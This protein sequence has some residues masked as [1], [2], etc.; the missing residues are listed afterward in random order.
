[1]V[2]GLSQALRV[3]KSPVKVGISQLVEAKVHFKYILNTISKE[4][5]LYSIGE[6][7]LVNIVN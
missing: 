2:A 7:Y 6:L 3:Q 5:V 4:G 1:M